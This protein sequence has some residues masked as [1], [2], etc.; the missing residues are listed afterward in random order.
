[1]VHVT[2]DHNEAARLSD[3]VVD[4]RYLGQSGVQ[5]Q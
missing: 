4:V 5:L 2:H 3:R 1:V